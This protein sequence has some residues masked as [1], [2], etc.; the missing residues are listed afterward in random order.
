MT[1]AAR[2]F[3]CVRTVMLRSKSRVPLIRIVGGNPWKSPWI[4]EIPGS[5]RSW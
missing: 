2:N 4:G 5:R 3:R 1:P